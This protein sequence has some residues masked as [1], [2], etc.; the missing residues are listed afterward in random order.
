MAN[1]RR[2]GCGPASV[3]AALGAAQGTPGPMLARTVFKHKLMALGFSLTELPDEDLIVLDPA[4][5][6]KVSRVGQQHC[7]TPTKHRHAGCL[8]F[9]SLPRRWSPC[10]LHRSPSVEE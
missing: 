8:L 4:A 10:A 1:S 3:G 9:A 2:L 5:T 7:T 6:G